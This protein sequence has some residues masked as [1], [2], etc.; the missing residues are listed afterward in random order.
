MRSND[1][2]SR[3]APAA[4]SQLDAPTLRE[5]ERRKRKKKGKMAA[6][7]PTSLHHSMVCLF[8]SYD[9]GQHTQ[10]WMFS[11]SFRLLGSWTKKTAGELEKSW[12]RVVIIGHVPP[13]NLSVSLSSS[14]LACCCSLFSCERR[15]NWHDEKEKSQTKSKAK[16]R[17]E[18][19]IDWI[20]IAQIVCV[21]FSVGCEAIALSC[22]PWFCFETFFLEQKECWIES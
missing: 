19:P 22:S 9:E 17:K 14:R 11:V 2:A 1:A 8:L 3:R 5:S 13:L 18:T 10:W 6:C 16:K 21:L 7:A 20:F 12:G 15:T 4:S